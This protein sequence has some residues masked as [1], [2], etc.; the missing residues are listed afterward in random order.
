MSLAASA[1]RLVSLRLPRE[2]PL[3]T[4]QPAELQPMKAA[5]FSG[6]DSFVKPKTNKK[7]LQMRILDPEHY[8]GWDAIDKDF[9]VTSIEQDGDECR[10]LVDRYK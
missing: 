6:E 4:L 8:P 1:K 2:Q 7:P 5:S 9:A 10:T 3:K